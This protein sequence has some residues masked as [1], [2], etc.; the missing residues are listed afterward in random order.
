MRAMPIMFVFFLFNF[1]AGLFVYWVTTNL[2]TIGQ[3]LI[4][5]RTMTSRCSPPVAEAPARAVRL[6]SSRPPAGRSAAASWRP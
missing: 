1:P 2:W 3:Q 4:I 6:R 5:R